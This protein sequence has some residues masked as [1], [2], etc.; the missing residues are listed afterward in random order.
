MTDF[1]VQEHIDQLGRDSLK[2]L[3]FFLNL[4]HTVSVNKREKDNS[5]NS[6]VEMSQRAAAER[7][8]VEVGRK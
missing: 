2:L 7:L 6:S 8:S 4:Q 1:I 5:S 3:I